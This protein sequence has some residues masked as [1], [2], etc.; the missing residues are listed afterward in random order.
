MFDTIDNLKLIYSEI[1]KGYSVFSYQNNSFFI[2]HLNHLDSADIDIY[3]QVC[4]EKAINNGMVLQRDKLQSIIKEGSWSDAKEM[5]I[6]E[7]QDFIVN[8]KQTKQKVLLDREKLTIDNEINTYNDRLFNLLKDK[9][10]LIGKTAEDFASKKVNEYYLYN[11]LYQNNLFDKRSFTWEDFDELDQY[12]LQN[13]L[14]LYNKKIE[15]FNDIVLKKVALM[16]L[17]MN[18]FL[19]CE[20]DIYAFFGKPVI[21]LSFY[22]IDLFQHAKTFKH[23]LQNS[24]V[25][26]PPEI[27]G[28]PDK[29]LEWFNN[30][31][32][33]TEIIESAN[34]PPQDD[35][36]DVVG[37]TSI[38]G[39][40]S[41]DYKKFGMDDNDNQALMKKLQEKGELTWQDLI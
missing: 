8:L 34:R 39:A 31:N 4:L 33:A 30:S 19:L 16:P 9:H 17:F 12:E 3:K 10:G 29:L 24:K 27:M 15:P 18:L 35:K 32:K 2:K 22:Q 11:S 38:V 7:I 28:D 5:E 37:G 6:K 21:T 20:N 13:I 40:K 14:G 26:P 25:S 41:K 1:I 23:I 36:H